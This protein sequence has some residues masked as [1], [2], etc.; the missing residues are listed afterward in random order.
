MMM[1]LGKQKALTDADLAQ[2][3]IP[4]LVSVGDRDPMVSLEETVVVSKQLQNG[5]LLVL[6]HTV[7]PLEKISIA[8]LKFECEQFF[9]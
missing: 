9:G 2:I 1:G 5:A 8:R 4:V 3:E 6:P 7:H